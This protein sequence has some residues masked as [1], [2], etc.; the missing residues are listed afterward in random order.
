MVHTMCSLAD[1]RVK[2]IHQVGNGDTFDERWGVS[3]FC[4][5]QVVRIYKFHIQGVP[6]EWEECFICCV[7]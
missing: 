6:K 3:G 2:V 7:A 1:K 4:I 5:M